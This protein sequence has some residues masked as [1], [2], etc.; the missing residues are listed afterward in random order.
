MSKNYKIQANATDEKFTLLT[1]TDSVIPI[2]VNRPGLINNDNEDSF[3]EA[4]VDLAT[5]L[6]YVPNIDGKD[7]LSRPEDL[8]AK[9]NRLHFQ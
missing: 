1:N 5:E 3:I 7:N 6:G 9:L 8:D 2:Q 4:I